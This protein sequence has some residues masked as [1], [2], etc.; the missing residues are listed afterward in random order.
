MAVKRG[1][2]FIIIGAFI[3]LL[4]I[5]GFLI[6][7]I[8]MYTWGLPMYVAFLVGSILILIGIYRTVG[9]DRAQGTFLIVA[10]IFK[11]P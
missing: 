6:P 9:R 11:S 2:P 8:Y 3:I 1:L 7:L 5:L 10:G 4:G